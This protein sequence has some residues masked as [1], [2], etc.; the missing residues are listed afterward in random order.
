MLSVKCLEFGVECVVSRVWSLAV[1]GLG[2]DAWC[3]VFGVSCFVFGVWGFG[4]VV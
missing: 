2:C 1:S 3:L 4:F